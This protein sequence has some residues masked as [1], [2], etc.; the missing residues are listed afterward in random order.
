MDPDELER[1]FVREKLDIQV[2]YIRDA[3]DGRVEMARDERGDMDYMYEQGVILVRDPYLRDVLVF[4]HG[5]E[6]VRSQ[7]REQV[8]AI[9]PVP[10][11]EGVLPGVTLLRLP[12][13]LSVPAALDAVDERFGPGIATPNHVLSITPVWPC[14]AT[15]PEPVPLGSQPDPGVCEG[16]GSG[17]FIYV[18]DT[19]LLRSAHRHPWLA[20]V[21]GEEDPPGGIPVSPIIRY[22]G[23]GTFVAGVARCMAPVSKVYV[24]RDFNRA[25]ALTEDLIVRR[26]GQALGVGANVINLSAGATTRKNLPL[27]AFEAFWEN[28]RHYNGVILVASAGNNSSRR[29]FWPA[30]F[31]QVV[32]V[33]ALSADRRARAF[34]SDFGPSVD[35]YAPGEDL[36]NAYA[37][38]SYKCEEP[39]N[40]G[41]PPRHFFGMAR[42]SGTSFSAPLVAGLI[43]ARMSRT[44]ENGRQAADALL[45]QA[46]SQTIPGV[47]PVLWPCDTGKHGCQAGCGCH[48]GHGGCRCHP[49][50]GH[51]C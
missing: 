25:G 50:G 15:E 32:G 43:A 41:T 6:Q 8:A 5:L 49:G 19:G 4:L 51:G 36:I 37:A 24:S 31:P 22:T 40:L 17:V 42:W 20:G 18:A 46:R 21:T 47:G 12:T 10:E 30:A 14:P 9:G 28:Y 3:F 48:A 13:G 11:A 29:P 16:G 45:A 1:Q 44:G 7:Q 27:L 39:P 35:V 23:H 2:S 26:L 38:G 34:F 33:G